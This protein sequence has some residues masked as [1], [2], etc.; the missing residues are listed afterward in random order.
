M[1]HLSRTVA[2]RYAA[3]VD[4]AALERWKH[5]LKTMT[6]IYRDLPV[7]FAWDDEHAKR[8]ASER[9]EEARKLFRNYREGFSDWVYKVVLPKEQSYEEKSVAKSTWDFRY[10]LDAGAFLFPSLHGSTPDFSS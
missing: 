8:E 3:T 1:D 10:T 7:D 6:K 9:F 4:K 2:R 5:D